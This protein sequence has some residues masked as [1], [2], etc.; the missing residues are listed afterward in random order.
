M[1]APPSANK[2][3]RTFWRRSG[4]AWMCASRLFTCR[5]LESKSERSCGGLA[6]RDEGT[7]ERGEGE[8]R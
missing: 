4:A 1:T 2:E 5:M 3:P 7:R 8:G 6:L